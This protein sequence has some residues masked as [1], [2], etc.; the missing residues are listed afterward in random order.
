VSPDFIIEID[1]SGDMIKYSDRVNGK[2]NGGG[3]AID[4]RSDYGKIY[5]RKK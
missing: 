5:L 3:M 2:L 4:F 1:K